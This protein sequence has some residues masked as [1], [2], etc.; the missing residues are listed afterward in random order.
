M[1]ET[2]QAQAKDLGIVINLDKKPSLRRCL[3]QQGEML[4]EGQLRAL[5]GKN[6]PVWVD[7]TD[8]DHNPRSGVFVVEKANDPESVML[9]DGSCFALDFQFTGKDKEPCCDEGY[10]GDPTAIFAAVRKKKK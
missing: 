2:I 10:D 8:S 1:K 4:N 6:V 5:I 9:E 7:F 3:Y